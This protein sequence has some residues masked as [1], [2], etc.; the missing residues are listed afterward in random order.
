[1]NPFPEKVIRRYLLG[2]LTNIEFDYNYVDGEDKKYLTEDEFETLIQWLVPDDEERK[3]L[4]EKEPT[5]KEGFIDTIC[6]DI[7]ML[8]IAA[9]EAQHVKGLE[10]EEIQSVI[11][12]KINNAIEQLSLLKLE[13]EK[14]GVLQS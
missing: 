2:M 7:A 5:D 3:A 12:T 11:E 13:L 14:Y 8:H 4:R 9:L 6:V 1:M 10:D